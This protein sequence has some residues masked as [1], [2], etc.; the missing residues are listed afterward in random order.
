M[1]CSDNLEKRLNSHPELKKYMVKLLDLAED[2]G[3]H[4]AD[5][6]EIE[7]SKVIPSLAR[8]AIEEWAVHKESQSSQSLRH[9]QEQSSPDV[10]KNSTGAQPTE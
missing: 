2:M 1:N 4:R 9:R 8:Q 3:V 5:D 10:K 6:I 7:V